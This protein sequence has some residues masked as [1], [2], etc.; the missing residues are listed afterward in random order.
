MEVLPSHFDAYYHLQMIVP[1][2]LEILLIAI[3]VS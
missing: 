1:T 2:S 3:A